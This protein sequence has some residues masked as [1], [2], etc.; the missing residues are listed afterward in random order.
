[1]RSIT[2]KLIIAFLG[3]SLI[4]ISMVAALAR[5]NTREEFNNFVFD[6]NRSEM[7]TV[8]ANYY[9]MQ[10]NWEGVHSD[11]FSPSFGLSG[12]PGSRNTPI[13]TLV[14]QGG[15]V[16]VE[17]PGYVLGET[18]PVGMIAGEIPI[19]VDNQVVGTLL[20]GKESFPVNV[21]ESSFITRIGHFLITV[22]LSVAG[23]ALILGILL[24]YNITRPIHQLIQVTRDISQGTLGGQVDV[25]TKDEIGRLAISFNKMSADLA[26]SNQARKQMTADISHELRTPLSLIIGQTEAVH[27][28]VLPPTKENFEIIRDEACRLERLVDDLR[29]LS[30]ADAGE[31]II[32]PQPV[33]PAKLVQEVASM[34]RSL[35][36]EKQIAL[37]LQLD[38]HMPEI[39]IDPG[40]MT[41]VLSNILDNAIRFTHQDGRIIISTR[42]QE[43]QVE[44][45]VEDNGHG[46]SKEELERIFERMYRADAS[47]QND[48]SGSGSGLG[49]A[50]A[51]SIVEMHNGKI[52]A[53][54]PE[55]GGLRISIL[56][57]AAA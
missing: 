3:V 19:S 20:I 17:G 41:Q 10:D 8:L 51:R 16:V 49:L 4:S 18:V 40:R 48:Q 5:W 53:S 50:I 56:L 32:T 42:L 25:R 35:L 33:D 38:P 24:A 12:K 52:Q 23:L 13:F 57:P 14:D 26:R 2:T 1:M 54:T 21:M 43:G 47:R 27:D 55:G 7:V 6:R 22:A 36:K 44:M 30:L 9:H 39:S 28:G 34:Y 46:V 11:I 37:E 45:A 15:V 31:L 29:I